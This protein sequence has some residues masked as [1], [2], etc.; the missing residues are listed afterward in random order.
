[1]AYLF[2]TNAI[3][4]VFRR[5]PNPDYVAWLRDLPRELQ[6]T[7]V[8]VVGELLAGA[9]GAYN[10]TLWLERYE[11]DVIS[12]LTVL[13]FDLECARVYGE[14]RSRLRAQGQP[15]GEAD[16]LIAATAL[17]H[18]LVVVTANTRHFE[19][20]EG[21]STRPFTPGQPGTSN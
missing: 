18:G 11:R 19:R 17:C 2:D 1:M 5:K 9:R 21:L 16:G 6:Y 10:P 12:R 20:V 15:I 7:S 4:E 3:S 8:I 13:A 14:V